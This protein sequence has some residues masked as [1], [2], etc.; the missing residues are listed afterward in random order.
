[1][2][3]RWQ[4]LALGIAGV[5]AAS[6]PGAAA[7]DLAPLDSTVRALMARD[8]VPGV[9]LAVVAGDS[10]LALRGWGLARV[11]DSLRVD[12][13]RTTF[14]VASVAKLFVATV[15]SM[16]AAAG[17]LDLHR[18]VNE[19]LQ[20]WQVPGGPGGA[21]TLHHLLTHT[22]GFDERLIGYAAR[23]VDSIAP[24]GEYLARNL[25]NRG[26]P[27]G[28]V[29]G[30]S[31]HGM[32]LAAHVAETVAGKTFRELAADRLFRPLGMP[33]TQ[34]VAVADSIA[35]RAGKGHFCDETRCVEAPEVFSHPY[36]VGLAWSTA[37]DM[38]R[39]VRAL[40]GSDRVA[41][42][43]A[44]LATMTQLQFTHDSL[45][46]G[47]SYGFF[48]Q[49]YRGRHMLAHAGTVPGTNNLLLIVPGARVGFY[50]V[51]NGGRSRFGES[52]R[53]A[54]LDMLFPHDEMPA[55]T[56]ASAKL[57][58]D[59][60]VSLAGPYQMTRYAHRTIEAFPTLFATGI[61]LSITEGGRLSVPFPNGAREFEPV[62][63]LHFR[64]VDGERVIGFRRD[65]RGRITHL[66]APVP[67]FGAELPAAFERLP[68]Y[69]A[70]HFVNEY[71]S[72]LLLV[73]VIVVAA[74]WPLAIAVAWFRR[75]RGAVLAPPGS[76]RGRWVALGAAYAFL[77][78][79]AV[80]GFLFVARS[81]R[82]LSQS[83]GIV[84]GLSATDYA[85]SLLPVVLALLA[86][87]ILIFA[88]RA[89][90]LRRWDA[91]RRVLYTLVAVHAV[92][93]LAFLIRWNYLPPG[94]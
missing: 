86:L 82:E 39:F 28:L 26:W 22:A 15:V 79:W 42:P 10:V 56:P 62:D 91:T 59:Y 3:R 17:A 18:D 53:N 84:H 85:L 11:R 94:Y 50:F 45:L 60:A 69:G 47:M 41:L 1:M 9:A 43:P 72:W 31:N 64:E 2:T 90:M 30:Y 52:L 61:P 5:S 8:A 83:R 75:R 33:R 65:S 57:S 4:L 77:A 13:E 76:R 20:G 44:A 21:I 92:L 66:F 63:S 7:Q 23:S 36:P 37:A 93:V 55:A 14:R 74:A 87:Q 40:L 34:Y 67:V 51:A 16:Q 73:P 49:R 38:S 6:A 68:W 81:L 48:R 70:P 29:T 54:L 27:P 12:P 89:W 78:L 24:L 46:A 25:P 35:D 19:Y 80:F 71:V 88:A 58:P 32:A